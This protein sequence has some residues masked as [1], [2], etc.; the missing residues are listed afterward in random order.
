MKP[1]EPQTTNSC[2]GNCP[3]AVRDLTG[4]RTADRGSHGRGRGCGRKV[5]V[6]GGKGFQDADLG[7]IEELTAPQQRS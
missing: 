5:W 7:E 6:G 3:D 4:F 2:W 1:T